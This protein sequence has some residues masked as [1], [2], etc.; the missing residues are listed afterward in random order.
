MIKKLLTSKKEITQAL[1]ER[2]EKQLFRLGVIIDVL[3]ALMIY[4]LFTFMP[5]PEIDGF[6]RDELYKVLTE[7]YLN[8]TV[9]FIGLVLII[10]YWGM[11]NMQFGNLKRTNS[12]HS[13]LSILQIFT[14]ML[15]IYFVRLDAQFEGEVLL[16]QMQ[17]IFLALAGFLSLWSW[18]YALKNN[19]V[20]D[21]PSK[22]EKE[23]MYIKFMPE[24]VVS[25]ITLPLA[26]FGP[27][28][29]T[30]GWLLLIPAGWLVKKYI[31]KFTNIEEEEINKPGN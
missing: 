20:G 25:L 18:H 26:Y 30:L 8:Y 21:A 31:P 13:T 2:G 12:M 9:I 29:W 6:G 11:S 4:K 7:S 3:Y 5:N 19:L 17:S 22:L 23:T 24:P 16:M 10:L 15:Y 27:L 1:V 28:V 14:L